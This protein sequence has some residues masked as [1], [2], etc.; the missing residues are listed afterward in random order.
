MAEQQAEFVLKISPDEYMFLRWAAEECRG[1][2]DRALLD[3]AR[4]ER[5]MRGW[6]AIRG[7][8]DPDATLILWKRSGDARVEVVSPSPLPRSG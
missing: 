5:I 4:W 7:D 3:E 2:I 6:L 1:I 8:H